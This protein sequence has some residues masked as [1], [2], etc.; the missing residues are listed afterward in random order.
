M[1]NKKINDSSGLGNNI[2]V[3]LGNSLD[4]QIA[5]MAMVDNFEQAVRENGIVYGKE[6][7][8]GRWEFVISSPREGERYPVVMH[9]VLK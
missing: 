7:Y 2:I 3:T 1:H 6:I 4:S 5:L 8:S 9:A